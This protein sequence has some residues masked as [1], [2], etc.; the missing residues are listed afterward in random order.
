MKDVRDEL[1]DVLDEDAAGEEEIEGIREELDDVLD[2]D[3]KDEEKLEEVREELDDDPGNDGYDEPEDEEDDEENLAA[4]AERIMGA[5][6]TV[7]A[8][9]APVRIRENTD[10]VPTAPKPT[11]GIPV[12]EKPEETQPTPAEVQ[13]TE[14]EETAKKSRHKKLYITAVSSA[15]ALILLL[16]ALIITAN[17]ASSENRPADI[18]IGENHTANA[19]PIEPEY[20]PD[21]T[22]G[23]PVD[24]TGE[25]TAP[26]PDETDK[27]AESDAETEEIET[28]TEPETEPVPVRY[29]VTLDF[30][31][32]E[33]I[34]VV[35]EAITLAD[36]LAQAGCRL[37]DA[38]VPSVSLDTVI[39]ADS[40]IAI[41]KRIWTTESIADTIP[42]ETEVIE[43]D[44]IPRG[45]T[46]YLQAGAEGVITRTYTVEYINGVEVSRT[47]AS[48][49]TTKWPVKE[50]YELGVGGSFTGADGNTYTYSHRRVVPATYYNLEGLTYLGT[51]ADENVIAVDMNYIPL[52]TK[53]YVKNDKY[54]FGVRIASD[55]GSMIKEWEIDIWIADDNPQL[56][57]FAYIGYHWDMEIY[58]I[59]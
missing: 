43:I 21:E 12:R 17:L 20:V 22:D 46:N 49:E 35:T 13:Q 40:T 41:D 26:V 36:L 24:P 37:T 38:D 33:D 48:E 30:Y 5:R 2:D 32:R 34:T 54:D 31:D 47:L 55:I 44:T 7:A 6:H 25:E 4:V 27:P 19:Q 56:A 15:V 59:D 10:R 1:E 14:A 29:T 18:T 8:T 51:M 11:A 45:T 3:V 50:R 23:E 39:A 57:D 16:T 52:G 58:Y 53:L 28:E 42:Y 9:A